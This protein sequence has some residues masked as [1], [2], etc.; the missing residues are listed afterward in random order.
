M[1]DIKQY[2]ELEF[3]SEKIKKAITDATL[4][5]ESAAVSIIKDGN[6]VIHIEQTFA[7]SDN[8][9]IISI[10]DKKEI[11]YSEDLLEEMQ[12]VHLE[13]KTDTELH[14]A[15]KVS[16]IIIN[17]LS[18]QTEFVF[19]AVK[20]CFDTLSSSYQFVKIIRKNVNALTIDF[21]FGDHKFQIVV[22]NNPD[23][24]SITVEFGSGA[25]PKVNETIAADVAKVQQAL[26]K[27][28]KD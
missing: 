22:T 2:P 26:N 11:L 9:A 24:V 10:T 27:L 16:S 17:G 1:S 23:E 25:N 5:K 7:A 12:D 6:D 21:K 19:Q 8:T 3:I 14:A 20:D 4:Q 28:F 18:V 15:L 13:T